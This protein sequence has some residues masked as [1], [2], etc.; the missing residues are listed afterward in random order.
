[1][2]HWQWQIQYCRRSGRQSGYAA[3]CT[4]Q[5]CIGKIAERPHH[6]LAAIKSPRTHAIMIQ[7]NLHRVHESVGSGWKYDCNDIWYFEG[8]SFPLRFFE[9]PLW[10]SRGCL[11]MLACCLCARALPREV[12]GWDGGHTSTSTVTR[13][14]KLINPGPVS[15]VVQYCMYSSEAVMLVAGSFWVGSNHFL[16]VPPY[17]CFATTSEHGRRFV[18]RTLLVRV[19]LGSWIW[20]TP[21]S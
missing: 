19:A 11:S 15:T 2:T 20:W 18:H 4:R 10:R 16:T 17:P 13:T 7:D 14:Q 21:R 3:Y 12:E 8:L 1:M 5:Y 9:W 6:Q